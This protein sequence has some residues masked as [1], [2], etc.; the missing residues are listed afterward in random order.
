MIFV[1]TAYL[2]ALCQPADQLHQRALAW[3][4]VVAE[5]LLTTDYVLWEVVNGLSKPAD[6][7]KAHFTVKHVRSERN[8]EVVA[9]TRALFKKGLNLHEERQDK[10]WSLTDCISFVVMH[11]RNLRRA[12]SP[13]HHFEQAGYEALLRADPPASQGLR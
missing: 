4:A 5:P 13:D 10:A 6:R 12:L 7:Q 9:A 1:N 8:W 11:Q 3:A 2:L